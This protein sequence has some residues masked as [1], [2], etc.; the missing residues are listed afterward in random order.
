MLNRLKHC[1][2][3]NLPEFENFILVISSVQSLSHVRLFVTPWTTARQASVSRFWLYLR[4]LIFLLAILILACASS[5]LVFHRDQISNICWI[6][7]K[8][9]EFQKNITHLKGAQAV[10]NIAGRNINNLRYTDDSTLMAES[11]EELKKLDESERGEW[12]SWLKTQR[13]ENWDHGT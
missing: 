9:R 12:K 3:V 4:L 7:E 1:M 8:A 5:S 2:S 10:I 11:E 6:I 13:S